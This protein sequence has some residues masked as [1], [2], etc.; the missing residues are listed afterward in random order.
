[1][2]TGVHPLYTYLSHS[3]ANN[4]DLPLRSHLDFDVIAVPEPEN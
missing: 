1:M 2:N 3:D 4:E